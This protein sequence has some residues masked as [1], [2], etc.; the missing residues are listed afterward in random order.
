M[1][2]TA[3]TSRPSIQLAAAII[4]TRVTTYT[5]ESI[6]DVIN[7]FCIRKGDAIVLDPACG[8]GSFLVRS[9]YRKSRLD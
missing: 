6:V 1:K 4:P 5:D 8:S 9:W 7:A 3:N 2:A